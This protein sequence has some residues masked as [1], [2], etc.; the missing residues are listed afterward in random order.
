MPR[1]PFLLVEEGLPYDGSRKTTGIPAVRRGLR[2]QEDSSNAL[3]ITRHRQIILQASGNKESHAHN[4]HK[5][6][7]HHL[8]MLWASDCTEAQDE[9]E[10]VL[11]G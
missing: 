1:R 8:Q 10:G 4:H 9:A 2:V 11:L 6:T 3:H 5:A 7:G